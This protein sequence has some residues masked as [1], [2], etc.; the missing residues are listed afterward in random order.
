MHLALTDR[1]CCPRCGPE[2]GLILL[3]NDVRE[4]RVLDG[5]LGCS[6]CRDTYPVRGGFADL[7]TP[8]RAS[9]P[10]PEGRPSEESPDQ[11]ETLRLGALLGVTEGPAT[12]LLQGPASSFAKALSQILPAVEMVALDSE[13]ARDEER[14]G[15]SRLVADSRIPFFPGSFRG[16]LL[17][18]DV[19]RG[20][21]EEGSRVLAQES[22]L[23][24]L[25]AG[26][27]AASWV[28]SQNLRVLLEED[29]VVVGLREGRQAPNLVTLRG[30]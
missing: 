21:V 14:N 2:F 10:A 9:L 23:V 30:I 27:E 16:V 20:T 6:N 11:E 17:S 18:G 29:S 1:L 22:R 24:V 3:A 26:D 19:D 15:V 7:R 4:K 8:P 13:R 5:D 25:D 12:L 28:R